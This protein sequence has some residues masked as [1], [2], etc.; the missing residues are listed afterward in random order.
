M[1]KRNSV[2]KCGVCGN[3][4]E[5]L[6]AGDGTLTCHGQPMT[7]LEGST[8]DTSM[9]KHVPFIQ[10]TDR[11]YL[12]KVGENQAH[13]MLEA[14]YIVWIELDTDQGTF[15][16]FLKP[17]DKPEAEFI[18]EGNGKVTGAREFCNIHGLWKG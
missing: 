18:M 1:L 14:H 12:V 7:Y 2:Y 13:P 8:A 16:K 15:R 17:G 11:G 5:V 4:V 6:M 10:K 9:E 3:T